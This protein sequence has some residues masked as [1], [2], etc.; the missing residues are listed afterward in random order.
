[1]PQIGTSKKPRIKR[2]NDDYEKHGIAKY[3]KMTLGLHI[4]EYTL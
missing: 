1:M 3:C 4:L 2:K